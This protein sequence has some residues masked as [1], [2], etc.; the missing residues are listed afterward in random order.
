[1]RKIMLAF[2]ALLFIS[3]PAAPQQQNIS[4]EGGRVLALEKAWNPLDMLLANTMVS[5]DIDGSISSRSEFLA[6]IKSSDYQPSQAIT[7]QST[8]QVYGNTAVVVGIFRVK[9]TEKSKPYVRRERFVDTWI[10]MN[11]TW[12]CVVT[13]STLITAK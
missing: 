11:G 13:T 9:G 10:K 6:S 5:I 1:M 3:V 8:V 2:L 7:E 12:Q 4:D